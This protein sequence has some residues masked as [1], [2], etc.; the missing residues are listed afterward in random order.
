LKK[1]SIK[2]HLAGYSIYQKR[3]TTINHAFASAIAP[4][5]KYEPEK[6]DAALRLL[7]QEPDGDLCCVYCGKPSETWDDLVGLVKNGELNGYGHQLGN[8]VPCCKRCNSKK[9]TKNWIEHLREEVPEDAEFEKRSRLISSYLERYASPVD[10]RR[11]KE[12]SPAKWKR[13]CQIKDE[14]IRLMKEA[15]TLTEELRGVVAG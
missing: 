12:K 10:S 15:D 8:L 2:F 1:K 6:L 9:G 3:V 4:V 5:D 7:N 13:F 14:I 11:A